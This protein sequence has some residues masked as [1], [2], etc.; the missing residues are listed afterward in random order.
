MKDDD[1]TI[2]CISLS[3]TSHSPKIKQLSSNITQCLLHIEQR[4]NVTLKIRLPYQNMSVKRTNRQQKSTGRYILYIIL[5][6]RVNL[7][8]YLTWE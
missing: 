7:S 8:M 5:P 1:I 4:I 2:I 6:Y 3:M